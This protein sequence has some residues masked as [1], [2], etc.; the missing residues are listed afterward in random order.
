MSVMGNIDLDTWME[1]KFPSDQSE[2]QIALKRFEEY[3]RNLLGKIEAR[4][5][6]LLPFLNLL[7]DFEEWMVGFWEGDGMVSSGS[8]SF[9]QKIKQPLEYIQTTTGSGYLRRSSCLWILSYRGDQKLR[10]LEVLAKNVV[11][12]RRLDQLRVAFPNL[13]LPLYPSDR[14]SPNWF[15]GFWDAEGYSCSSGGHLS[16]GV[17]QREKLPL[18]AI[19][20]LWGCGRLYYSSWTVN[21]RTD[22]PA[23]C[24]L[25]LQESKNETKRQKLEKDIQMVSKYRQYLKMRG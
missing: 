2:D 8:V 21:R 3:E 24:N 19:Q 11:S 15:V 1:T 4:R 13:D 22:L 10:L 17:S 6:R 9:C 7:S 23:I 25:L 12:Q 18:E 14:P 16:L 5:S 20:Q